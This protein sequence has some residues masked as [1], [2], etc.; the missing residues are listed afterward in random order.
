[1]RVREHHGYGHGL[2]PGEDRDLN[3]PSCK[4]EQQSGTEPRITGHEDH[5]LRD[6]LERALR[7]MKG[8]CNH[9]TEAV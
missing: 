1:M 7:A 8:E 6:C 9:G 5:T 4:R 3:C 2:R